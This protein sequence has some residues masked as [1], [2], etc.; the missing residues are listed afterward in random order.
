MTRLIIAAIGFV[1]AGAIFFLYTQPAYNK[2]Q[3]ERTKIAQYDAAL[4]KAAEL[5][6]LK[7]NLLD[8]YNAFNSSDVERLQKLLPDHVDNVRLILDLDSLAGRYGLGLQNVEVSTSDS[9]GSKSAIG[10]IGT[11]NQKYESL[12]L[13]FATLGTYEAFTRFLSD[14]ETSLRIVDLAALSITS[15]SSGESREPIYSFKITLRTYW[16]K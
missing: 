13:T 5:Q 15:A 10:V 1:I 4:D 14:L 11:S 6:S 9:G 7:Q 12:T 3:G 8:R 16:L 2:L